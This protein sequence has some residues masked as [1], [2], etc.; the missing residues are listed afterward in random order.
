MDR[1]SDDDGAD[2]AVGEDP[3]GL[4]RFLY[5]DCDM[6]EWPAA[7]G[8][9]SAEPEP[10]GE[11]WASFVRA[12]AAL[13]GGAT[14]EAEALWRAVA[15]RTDVE[16]RHVLQAWHFLRSIGVAPT[17]GAVAK[18]VLGVIAEVAVGDGHDVL[19]A[20]VDGSVRY[21]N[22]AGGGT[23][24][25][26]GAVEA[27]VA[28]ARAWLQVGQELAEL[29]EPWDGPLPELP[30][31]HTRIVM[32]TPSGPHFGQGPDEALQA[33]GAA[34]AFLGAATGVLIAVVG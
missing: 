7:T 29:I 34:S 23:S 32:L 15:D 1:R 20:Y 31:G 24:I 5:G 14:A 19:A 6:A 8:D 33:D 25:D 17:D 30:A 2:G 22:A 27:V 13:A 10:E 4:R 12:R 26:D 9:T 18:R 3:T 21:L 28:P 16:S 11:P